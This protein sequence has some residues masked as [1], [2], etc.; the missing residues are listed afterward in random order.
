MSCTI[1]AT[2]C[3]AVTGLVDQSTA[4][5]SPFVDKSPVAGTGR[6]D[7]P[8]PL[9]GPEPQR[10]FNTHTAREIL[11]LAGGTAEHSRRH[12]KNTAGG[13]AKTQ[14]EAQQKHASRNLSA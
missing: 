11:T 1:I 5:T 7:G 4:G 8:V 6:Q 9:P 10:I 3:P 13:T 14:Q 12:S 2:D